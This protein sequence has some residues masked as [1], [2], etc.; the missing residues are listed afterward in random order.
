MGGDNGRSGTQGETPK[1]RRPCRE[2]SEASGDGVAEKLSQRSPL[3][4]RHEPRK[5]N[6]ADD[7]RETPSPGW[8][9]LSNEEQDARQYRTHCK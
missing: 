3:E 7:R 9:S 2:I 5:G 6:G 1:V 4:E 8:L